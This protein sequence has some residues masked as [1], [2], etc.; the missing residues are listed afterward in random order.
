MTEVV[1]GVENVQTEPQARHVVYCEGLLILHPS[2][3]PTTSADLVSNL[4][5]HASARGMQCQFPLE[6]IAIPLLQ[7]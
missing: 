6:T 5:L 3:K 1:N 2:A 4:S 7:R